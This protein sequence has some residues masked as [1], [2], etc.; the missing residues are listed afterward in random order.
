MWR[1]FN[2]TIEE[3]GGLLSWAISQV[4]TPLM[5]VIMS[6]LPV[7]FTNECKPDFLP[8]TSCLNSSERAE[9]ERERERTEFPADR[10]IATPNCEGAG[11]PGPLRHL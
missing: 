7:L 9:R 4:V 1:H 8:T 5:A 3:V 11:V 6:A 2:K 10:P